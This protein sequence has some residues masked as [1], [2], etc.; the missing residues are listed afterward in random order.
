MEAEKVDEIKT[1]IEENLERY[2]ERWG[3]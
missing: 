3:F 2:L 1:I